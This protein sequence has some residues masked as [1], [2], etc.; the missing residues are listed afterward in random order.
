[1]EI[2]EIDLDN[3]FDTEIPELL[4]LGFT[5]SMDFNNRVFINIFSGLFDNDSG[6]DHKVINEKVYPVMIKMTG[7]I[8]KILSNQKYKKIIRNYFEINLLILDKEENKEKLELWPSF[9]GFFEKLSENVSKSK[10]SYNN[11]DKYDCYV[12]SMFIISLIEKILRHL[13]TKNSD[14]IEIVDH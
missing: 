5:H 7:L 13:A 8:R 11:K 14:N 12:M 6:N 10:N 9:N 4:V 2:N 1:M 3:F